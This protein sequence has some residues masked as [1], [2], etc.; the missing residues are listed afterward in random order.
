VRAF[1]DCGA[2][3]QLSDSTDL[4]GYPEVRGRLRALYE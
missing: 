2:V 1:P 3:D 4:L